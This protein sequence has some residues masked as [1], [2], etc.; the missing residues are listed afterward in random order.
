MDLDLNG[1]KKKPQVKTMKSYQTLEQA[2][3]QAPKDKVPVL[4]TPPPMMATTAMVPAGAY[5]ATTPTNGMMYPQQ[6]PQYGMP[7]PA[8][9]YAMAH[10]S[11]AVHA[12]GGMMQ[13]PP[14]QQHQQFMTNV[15]PQQPRPNAFSADPFATL[16]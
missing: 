14:M 11:A 9:G 13:Q 4:P 1:E 6:Q 5:Y 10:P 3:L 7:A 15:A 2:R 8:M 16:S 12:Y